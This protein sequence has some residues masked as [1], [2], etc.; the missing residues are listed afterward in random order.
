MEERKSL[1]TLIVKMSTGG[2]TD[3]IT[4]LKDSEIMQYRRNIEKNVKYGEYHV[5]HHAYTTS[6]RTD[7]CI[8]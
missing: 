5:K 7:N 6:R 1:L 3:K 4:R 8:Y 2:D